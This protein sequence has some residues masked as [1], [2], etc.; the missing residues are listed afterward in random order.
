MDF[1]LQDPSCSD[2]DVVSAWC[3]LLS[4]LTGDEGPVFYLDENVVRFNPATGAVENVEL[5]HEECDDTRL[6]AAL[7]IRGVC[8]SPYR[9]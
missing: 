1:A 6:Y 9:Y 4:A 8:S 7:S 3:S 5:V 2:K